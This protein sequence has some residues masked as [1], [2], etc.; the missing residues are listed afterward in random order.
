MLVRIMSIR[1]RAGYDRGFVLICRGVRAQS[2]SG[3]W[4]ELP[5][6]SALLS[7]QLRFLV[8]TMNY[9]GAA[10]GFA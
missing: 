6:A 8:G 4:S 5:L 2:A 10:S 9:V 1:G 7:L 3:R